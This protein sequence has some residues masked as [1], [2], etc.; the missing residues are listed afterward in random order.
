MEFAPIIRAE[1]E[2]VAV[3]PLSGAVPRVIEPFLKV[4]IPV[5]VP[6]PSGVIVAEK[7]TD[8]PELEGFTDEVI[9]V[10]VAGITDLVENWRLKYSV[11]STLS[12]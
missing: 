1:V 12:G 4:T 8:C 11:P 9:A 6:E 10:A 7:F 2:S 3:L 5:G